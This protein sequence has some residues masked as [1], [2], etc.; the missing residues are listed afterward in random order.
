MKLESANKPVQVLLIHL[1]KEI[2]ICL[3][4]PM[5]EPSQSL[6][7]IFSIDLLAKAFRY[8]GHF[9][10]P[11]KH[12]LYVQTRTTHQN[13]VI[14]AFKQLMNE[15]KRISTVLPGIIRY[16]EGMAINKMMLYCGEL[17]CSRFR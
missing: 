11:F 6:F 17:F 14:E 7:L 10:K 16:L 2:R 1:S 8:F 5:L 4:Y 15:C 9:I 3:F 13:E 12:S